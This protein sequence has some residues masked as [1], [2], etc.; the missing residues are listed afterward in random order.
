M[1]RRKLAV[2]WCAF[3]LAVA[4]VLWLRRS[5]PT[6]PVQS[7]IDEPSEERTTPA[8]L[9]LE[10]NAPRESVVTRASGV[11]PPVALAVEES[12]DAFVPARA[13]EGIVLRGTQPVGGG[14]A[15]LVKTL[16]SEASDVACEVL[17][18]PIAPVTAIGA[19]GV[20]RFAS[21]EP[22]VYCVSVDVEPGIRRTIAHHVHADAPSARLV[23]S[24]GASEIRGRVLGD[25]GVVAEHFVRLRGETRA[26]GRLPVVATTRTDPIGVYRFTGLAAGTYSVQCHAG[27][28]G[29][30]DLVHVDL[31]AD[32][33]RTVDL[34]STL[35]VGSWSGRMRGPD[36][37]VFNVTWTLRVVEKFTRTVRFLAMRAGMEGRFQL[38]LVPGEHEL[39]FESLDGWTSLG[40]LEVPPTDFERDVVLPPAWIV[41][42]V[43]DERGADVQ[44]TR[45]RLAPRGASDR[46]AIAWTTGYRERHFVGISPGEYDVWVDAPRISPRTSV[47]VVASDVRV[48]V[49]IVLPSD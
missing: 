25:G 5:D 17:R 38:E 20:F 42:R 30:P 14:E 33:V 24:I 28:R 21:V 9:Q 8:S 13:I 27:R 29:A 7:S 44:D 11:E 22:A 47:R 39:A 19:D 2:A 34:G 45:V 10:A 36:G 41:V 37:D 43:R 12:F 4:G 23:F 6:E 18:T 49:E 1:T 3:L 16:A 48:D 26:H 35:G 46:T 15:W 32:E 40:E 31:G